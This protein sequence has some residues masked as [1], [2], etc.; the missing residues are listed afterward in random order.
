MAIERVSRNKNRTRFE[1][2]F[3]GVACAVTEQSVTP[4]VSR[5]WRV[6]QAETERDSH[7][8]TWVGTYWN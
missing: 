8:N 1:M 3:A 4:F 7:G 2:G 6:R 5:S